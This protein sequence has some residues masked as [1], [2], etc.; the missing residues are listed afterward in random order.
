MQLNKERQPPFANAMLYGRAC[1]GN[2]LATHGEHSREV[3]KVL[4]SGMGTVEMEFY[5]CQN[6]IQEDEKR[7]FTVDRHDV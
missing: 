4:V 6:A 2:C 5:Y 1:E 3:E 7:G